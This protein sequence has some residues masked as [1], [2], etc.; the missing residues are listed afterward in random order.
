MKILGEELGEIG[1]WYIV[2]PPVLLI[3]FLIGL[4]LLAAAGQ[5]RL[6]TA[7]MRIHRPQDREEALDEFLALIADAE[8]EQRGYLLTGQESYLRHYAAAAA[9]VGPALDRLRRT[10]VEDLEP[11][12]RI[13]RLP[14]LARDKL[15]QLD[16][17]VA[18][19]RKTGLGPELA[20]RTDQGR[21][22]TEEILANVTVLRQR[23]SEELSAATE[24]W[25]SDLRM[26]RWIT[27]GGVILNIGLVLLATGLVYGDMR[28]AP[29]RRSTFAIRSA[30]SRARS[31]SAPGN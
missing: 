13:D 17:I 2:L 10:Y 24:R 8:S 20:A 5:S 3:G 22:L 18:L 21:H 31:A 27:L 30:N 23:Q 1:R 11:I 25:R 16:D 29:C 9:Q 14:A 15:A 12:Q 28:R 7:D 4:F 6:T 19:Y 26:S